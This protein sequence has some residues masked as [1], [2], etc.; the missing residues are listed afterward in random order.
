MLFKNVLDQ[1]YREMYPVFEQLL[2]EVF[3][4]Q[5][6]N[7]DLLLINENAGYYNYVEKWDNLEFKASPYMTGPQ[8]EGHSEDTHH[9]F[10]G[11]YVKEVSSF[12]LEEYQKIVSYDS[13]KQKEVEELTDL[14][15]MSVQIEMLIYIKIWESDTFIKKLY[16]L[17]RL[18]N[19]EDYDWHFKIKGHEKNDPGGLSRSV[20]IKDHIIQKFRH[21]FPSLFGYLNKCYKSQIRNAIAHSQYSILGRNISFNNYVET[22]SDSLSHLTFDEWIDLFH[23]TLV[24]Y[25]LYHEFFI[26]VNDI[27][28]DASQEYEGTV[29]IRISRLYP[30][31]EVQYRLLYTRPYFKDWNPNR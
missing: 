27:Y 8:M 26:R 19:G 7:G 16:E 23:E 18:V 29:E 15:S 6:H 9:K 12:T 3:N 5:T 11:Q 2:N 21:A 31:E 17:A 28:Y 25:T 22:N 24:F 14:E 13:A 4:K 1:K 30:I 10:I 20:L